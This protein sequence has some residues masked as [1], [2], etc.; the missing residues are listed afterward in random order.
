[1]ATEGGLISYGVDLSDMYRRAPLYIDRILKGTKAADLPVQTPV[2]FQLVIN[3]KTA[4]SMGL[5][6]PTSIQVAADDV[7]E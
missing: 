2:K 1:M 7:I 6:I 5:K 3:L 4:V